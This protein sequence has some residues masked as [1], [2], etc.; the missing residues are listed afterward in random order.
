MNVLSLFDGMSCGQI[1]LNKAGVRYDKYFASEIDEYAIKVTMTN[2]PQTIQLGDVTAIDTTSLPKIDLLIGGSP[3]QSFSSL[4][5]GSGLDGKSGLFWEF[6]KVLKEVKPK[7]FML[8]NVSM[9]KEWLDIV[10]DAVGVEP[11]AFNSNLVS[12][13]NR[14]RLYWTNIPFE[15]PVDKGLKYVDFLDDLPFDE[16]KPFMLNK[17]GDKSRIDKGVN[18]VGNDKS[19]CLTTKNCHLNQYLLNEDKTGMRLMNADEYERLQT[20]PEG[21]TN[22]VSNTQRIKMI[23]NGWTV[24]AIAHIFKNIRL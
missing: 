13:Q 3:C 21:Y 12:A 16:I 2:Y 4:G 6:V 9:K 15:L 1:A 10:S 20:I 18:W 23:G 5:D 11:I 19:N 17:W 24:D 14:N 8:E 7:Y 22:H